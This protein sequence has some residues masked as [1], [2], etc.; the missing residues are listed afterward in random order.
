MA[1]PDI[2]A[3][4]HSVLAARAFARQGEVVVDGT[5]NFDELMG[6]LRQGIAHAEQAIAL[7]SGTS[8][9]AAGCPFR[10]AAAAEAA[11]LLAMEREAT[12]DERAI[13]SSAAHQAILWR[14]SDGPDDLRWALNTQRREFSKARAVTKDV[15]SRVIHRATIKQLKEDIAELEAQLLCARGEKAKVL[16]DKKAALK[17]RLRALGVK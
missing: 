8:T 17:A 2:R 3:E 1:S 16:L 5:K 11:T 14:P 4:L 6:P 12:A 10:L 9:A 13:V 7:R 15:E